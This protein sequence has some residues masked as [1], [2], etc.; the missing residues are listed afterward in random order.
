MLAHW[1]DAHP[2]T[3]T[4]GEAWPTLLRCLFLSVSFLIFLL[5]LPP[6]SLARANLDISPSDGAVYHFSLSAC[7]DH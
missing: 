3:E 4:F 5:P 2:V 6:G 1:N 7:L